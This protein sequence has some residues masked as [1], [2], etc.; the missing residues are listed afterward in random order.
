MQP[1]TPDRALDLMHRRATAALP[2]PR[3]ARLLGTGAPDLAAALEADPRFRLLRTR[4][5]V[6]PDLSW[7]RGS[8]A[9]YGAALRAAG[10][11]GTCLVLLV[12]PVREAPDSAAGLLADTL[13][14]L[15]GA[16]AGAAAGAGA[17][18]EVPGP[19]PTATGDIPAHAFAE[20]LGLLP[21]RARGPALRRERTDRSTT[22]RPATLPSAAAPPARP[23]P[24]SRPTPRPGCRRG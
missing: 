5:P 12:E 18:P 19:D 6:A 1:P 23:R 11:G 3:L 20:A 17:A 16:A 10:L 14:R 7:P 2:L 8:D 9:A 24:S 4:P 21:T 13:V 22:P 15:L